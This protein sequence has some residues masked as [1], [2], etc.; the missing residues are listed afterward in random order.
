MRHGYKLSPCI[1]VFVPR[2]RETYQSLAMKMV[3]EEKY[4]EEM[5]GVLKSQVKGWKGYMEE[6]EEV[7]RLGDHPNLGKMEE[8]GK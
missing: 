8:E 7:Q 2:F 4:G 1:G 3:E 5:E 6:E